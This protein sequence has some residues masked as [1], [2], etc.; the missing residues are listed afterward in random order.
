MSPISIISNR[1]ASQMEHFT[2]SCRGI[3]AGV[4]AGVLTLSASTARAQDTGILV[5]AMAPS[6]TVETLDG[7]AMNLSDYYG[8]KPVVLEFWATWCPLCKRLEPAMDAARRKYAGKASF[9]SVGVSS[10]QSP[11]RQKAYA[12]K[13]KLGGEFVFDRTDAATKAFSVPHTS[14][15]VVI[16]KD[17]K[18]VYTGVGDEQNIDAAVAMAFAKKVKT[19]SRPR[20]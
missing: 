19:S 10:N 5:G 2:G 15:V 1:S 3:M 6:A 20:T 13:Q 9:V 14:Y 7:R 16:G 4:V 18:V 12:D 11:A 17:R 8:K